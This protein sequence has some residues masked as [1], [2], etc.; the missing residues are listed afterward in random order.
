MCHVKFIMVNSVDADEMSHNE[1]FHFDLHCL[2]SIIFGLQGL[3]GFNY[4]FI[5]KVP[6]GWGGFSVVFGFGMHCRKYCDM[7]ANQTCYWSHTPFSEEF[8]LGFLWELVLNII[9]LWNFARK[10]ADIYF[11]LD[12]E[13]ILDALVRFS[14]FIQAGVISR[15]MPSFVWIYLGCLCC[16]CTRFLKIFG[17]MMLTTS[18]HVEMCVSLVVGIWKLSWECSQFFSC[19]GVL[20]WLMCT[21]C[22]GANSALL[23]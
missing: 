2:Q 4:W 16:L 9:S 12:T 21:C 15:K 20:E 6:E 7:N 23:E 19:W 8:T 5:Y 17:K 13:Q 22:R 3:K 1:L 14:V 10:V 18:L 11:P